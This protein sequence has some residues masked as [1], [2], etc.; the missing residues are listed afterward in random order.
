MSGNASSANRQN[1]S[2]DD[3]LV[4]EETGVSL[5]VIAKAVFL[6]ARCPSWHP[7]NSDSIQTLHDHCVL[8]D[9]SLRN[10]NV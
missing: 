4:D 3:S 10:F 6:Q 8:V 1:E 7:I 2:T 9:F 5:P